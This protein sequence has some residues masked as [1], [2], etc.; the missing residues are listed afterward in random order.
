[1]ETLSI[2]QVILIFI[3]PVLLIQLN[4]IP[5]NKRFLVLLLT[6]VIILA[7]VVQEKWS[8][9]ILGLENGNFYPSLMPY[10]LFTFLGLI[11]II[12]AAKILNRAVVQN[13][14]KQPHFLYLFIIVSLVQEFAYRGF[15][16]PK[17]Q[18][19]FNSAGFVIIINTLLFTYLH[20]I[21]PNK[22]VNLPLIFM[23]GIG[24]STMYLYYPNLLLISLSHM[25]LNFFAVLYGFFSFRKVTI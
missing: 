8:L 14:W 25:I 23:G 5:V 22:K 9:T 6:T 15:L 17:L 2:V 10:I 4:I 3:L 1:M 19:I 20:I 21:F 18:L 16:I 13:W 11:S 12:I 24:F 7:I